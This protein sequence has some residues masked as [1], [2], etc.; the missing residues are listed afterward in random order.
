LKINEPVA[1][2]IDEQESTAAITADLE[3]TYASPTNLAPPFAGITNCAINNFADGTCTI[4]TDGAEC[5]S[6]TLITC[7]ATDGAGQTD[8]NY[9]IDCSN[10]IEGE[11]WNLCTDDVPETSPFGMS[12]TKI[13]SWTWNVSLETPKSPETPKSLESR[14][15]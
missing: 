14:S 13:G 12:P 4:T 1:R 3:A 5:N 8:E 6:C 11:V 15:L 7:D 9:D 10:V 2:S